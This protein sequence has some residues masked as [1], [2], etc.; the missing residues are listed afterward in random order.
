MSLFLA[1][2]LVA[3]N[4]AV[5][6]AFEQRRADDER[7][8]PAGLSPRTRRRRRRTLADLVGASARRPTHR[9]NQP[10][11]RANRPAL[12]TARPKAGASRSSNADALSRRHEN[13]S[14][15]HGTMT[16]ARNVKWSP[17]KT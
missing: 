5:A 12:D 10:R 2:A 3:R 9:H 7:R 4:L 14:H 11:L 17:R 16:T 13:M 6:D 15:R 8:A 1:C